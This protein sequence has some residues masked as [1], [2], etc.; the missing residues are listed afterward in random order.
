MGGKKRKIKEE[1][2]KKL[3]D[4]Q[5]ELIKAEIN[6]KYFRKQDKASA[7]TEWELGTLH[8]NSYWVLSDAR[9][10]APWATS[11]WSVT[12]CQPLGTLA[13]L[14]LSTLPPP[15]KSIKERTKN[16]LS[17]GKQGWLL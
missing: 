4:R 3:R 11:E 7:F 5:C 6:N 16:S 2:M 14:S 17:E 15:P 12:G 10:R 1:K 13:G 9:G 8:P